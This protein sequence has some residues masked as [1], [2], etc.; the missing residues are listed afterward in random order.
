MAINRRHI[1]GE[2]HGSF[3]IAI[4]GTCLLEDEVLSFK[5]LDNILQE[6]LVLADL[7]FYYLL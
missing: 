6:E 2:D 7:W 3:V 5:V 1:E 4:E